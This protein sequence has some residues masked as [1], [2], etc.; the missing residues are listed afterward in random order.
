[1]LPRYARLAPFESRTDTIPEE[2]LLKIAGEADAAYATQR[3]AS[4]L[5]TCR[6][7]AVGRARYWVTRAAGPGRDLPAS[8]SPMALLTYSVPDP[9][10]SRRT[11]IVPVPRFASLVP[12]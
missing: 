10:A 8:R 6:P 7:P 9:T 11:R 3:P 4:S 1:M 5:S 2:E 12:G